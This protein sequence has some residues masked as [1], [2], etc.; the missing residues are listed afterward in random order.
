MKLGC[1]IKWK[2]ISRQCNRVGQW[3]DLRVSSLTV[4]AGHAMRRR[5]LLPTLEGL[6]RPEFSKIILATDY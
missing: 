3:K 4:K 6:G 5:R 2:M 1:L